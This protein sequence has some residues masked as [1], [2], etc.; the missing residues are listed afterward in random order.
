M[1]ISHKN[2][3]YI[4]LCAAPVK[5]YGGGHFALENLKEMKVTKSFLGL[6]ED[7]R[8]CGGKKTTV[9]CNEDL[10][11]KEIVGTCN[12]VP[13]NIKDFNQP[14]NNVNICFNA[15]RSFNAE[16]LLLLY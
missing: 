14:E 7:I 11:M 4:F 6:D 10:L 5:R 1:L 13:L 8:K 16:P 2:L 9:E 12:C 15:C 3:N